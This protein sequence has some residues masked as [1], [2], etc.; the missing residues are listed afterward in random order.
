[1]TPSWHTSKLLIFMNP[2]IPV[3]HKQ[4]NGLY[5][6]PV[7][8]YPVAGSVSDSRIHRHTYGSSKTTLT[9][10]QLTRL[11]Q[12]NLCQVKVPVGYSRMV[13]GGDMGHILFCSFIPG[14]ITFLEHDNSMKYSRVGAIC[15]PYAR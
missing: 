1:M 8:T 6:T 2:Q 15:E 12:F 9:L 7:P 10:K 11:H 14:M 13:K 5:T 4:E 3:S